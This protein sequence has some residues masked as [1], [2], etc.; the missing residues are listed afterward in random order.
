MLANGPAF[1]ESRKA[2]KLTPAYR[3][4]LALVRTKGET[5]ESAHKRVREWDRRIRGPREAEPVPAQGQASENAATGREMD[6][7]SLLAP[8]IAGAGVSGTFS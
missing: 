5:I 4:A 3:A 7:R 6:H 2:A 8:A 1:F